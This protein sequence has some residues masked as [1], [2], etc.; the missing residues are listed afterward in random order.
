MKL[1]NYVSQMR[2]RTLII[3]GA[4]I[5]V[6]AAGSVYWFGFAMPAS[7]S[8]AAQ[9]PVTRT[10][11]ASLETLEKSVST[12]GTLA[13]TVQ[14]SAAFT[15][16]GTVTA[17]NV[18]AGQTVTAGQVLAT[19]DTMTVDAA[20]LQAKA[21]LATAQA[22]LADATSASDGSDA[23]AAQIAADQSSVDLAASAV[24]DAET[25]VSDA[26]LTAPVAGLVTSVGAAVG[27][28]VSAGSSASSSSS[29]GSG[30]SAAGTSGTTGTTGGTGTSGTTSG[31]TSTTSSSG[32]T[33]VS[34]DSWQVSVA[35]SE[36]DI[37]NVAKDDQVELSLTDGTAFFGTVASVGLLPST[38]S[39]AVTYPVVVSV[40]GSPTGLYDGVSV[41]AAIVYER[42]TNVLTVPSEAVT[43]A[44]GTSTVTTLD[45]E[46]ADV[47]TT[48]VVGETVG[49]LTEI[50]SGLA[51]GDSVVITVFTPGGTGT[52]GGTGGTGT[53]GQ[54]GEF[55]GGGAGFGGGT[56]TF[57]GGGT[58]TGGTTTG[59]TRS[60]T[61]NGATNG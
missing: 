26:T 20:L 10:V 18:A 27:D 16:S 19:V 6:V 22:K 58:G 7:S 54:T 47:Q 50:T 35:V 51:E 32:F 23:D 25:D 33:I 48:V 49:T 56:G 28:K 9:A 15:V 5:L 12:T 53:G 4:L 34:T 14:E 3:T 41:T 8:Q 45:A 2:R 21:T 37:A 36:S 61:R 60:T 40:T 44:N 39:G 55:P 17:V 42:R 29:S 43:T 24:T 31:T 46:G 1:K 57:P 11:Q 52:G 38:T 30:T 13:P 59:T